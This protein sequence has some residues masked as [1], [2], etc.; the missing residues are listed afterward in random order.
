[1]IGFKAKEMT[2]K[3][4]VKQLVN[5]SIATIF[6]PEKRPQLIIEFCRPLQGICELEIDRN[7]LSPAEEDAESEK[8]SKEQLESI[9]YDKVCSFLDTK[10]DILTYEFVIYL[11]IA[12][13]LN[14][15][16]LT[17]NGMTI[18]DF[19]HFFSALQTTSLL[20]LEGNTL[21]DELNAK[22]KEELKNFLK[23]PQDKYFGQ[24]T[25]VLLPLFESSYTGLP[26]D[27]LRVIAEYA[28]VTEISDHLNQSKKLNPPK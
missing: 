3:E 15:Q 2:P 25:S 20:F 18:I 13:T 14:L 1:M 19:K 4:L 12:K 22:E 24:Y 7:A 23:P 5:L 6:N 21:F 8:L 11:E 10:G 27:P 9:G 26:A 16:K 17:I 28:T